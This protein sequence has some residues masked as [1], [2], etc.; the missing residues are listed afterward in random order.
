M[1]PVTKQRVNADGVREKYCPKC[2]VFKPTSAFHKSAA[3]PDGLSAYCGRCRTACVVAYRQTT[4]GRSV[5]RKYDKTGNGRN[6]IKAYAQ[7]ESGK[8]MFREAARKYRAANPQK[9][10]ARNATAKAV[11][12]G[13]LPWPQ[14]L[15]CH[16]CGQPATEYHHHNGYEESHKTDVVPVCKSCHPQCEETAVA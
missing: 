1:R 16:S 8:A 6:A 4:H 11:R 9:V 2:A 13:K 15:V 3:R 7:S 12:R 10:R 14:T 5:R